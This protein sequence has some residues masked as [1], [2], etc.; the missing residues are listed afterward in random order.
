MSLD[1]ADADVTVQFVKGSHRWNKLFYPRIFE[2]G[3]DFNDD[4]T[5]T[6]IEP[7]PYISSNRDQYDIV[8]WVLEPGD[9]L[10]F[11][12]HTLHCTGAT[13]PSNPCGGHFQHAG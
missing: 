4:Q 8:A 12:F 9:T 1:H 2:G 6:G 10:V 11:D 7:V 5:D 13:P 3:S